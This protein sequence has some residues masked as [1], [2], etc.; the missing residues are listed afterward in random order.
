L[1]RQIVYPGAIPLD[2]DILSVQ[3]NTMLALGYLAESVFGSTT[4]VSGLAC[5]PTT[6]TADLHVNVQR[7]MISSLSTVDATA[8]GSLAADTSD[9]LVKMGINTAIW[10][11]AI[12]P[13][14]T[15]GYSQNY[16]IEAE[17]VETDTTPV[18]LPYYN[19]AAPSSP[20]S[21]PS[22][23]GVAQNT[24]RNQRVSLQLKPGTAAPAGT[25]LTPGV[26]SGWVG[27][28]VVTVNNGQTQITSADIARASGAPFIGTLLSQ[29]L[30]RLSSN[31]TLYVSPTGSDSNNGL[32][33]STA[34]ATL[35][36][37]YNSLVTQYDMAGF[38]A[39]IQCAAGTYAPL[40]AAGQPTGFSKNS[41][42]T[43]L[44]NAASPSTCVIAGASANAVAV[45]SGAQI[46][47]TGFTIQ[48][49]TLGNCLYAGL[50]SSIYHSNC[51]FG[52]CAGTHQV[53]SGGLILGLTSYSITGSAQYHMSASS[54]GTINIGGNSGTV[55]TLT[56]TPAFTAFAL[57]RGGSIL[58]NKNNVSFSGSATGSRFFATCGLIDTVGSTASSFF[59]GSTAGTQTAG[60]EYQ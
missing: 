35:N 20:Y 41:S 51:V 34:F 50:N 39:T 15:A 30:T 23:S 17:L 19:A 11:V 31:L 42:I 25:Q 28:Y 29:G 27:L 1:D 53:V 21:G 40:S 43:I 16:L 45:S 2:S 60:W 48:T 8:F 33:A 4:I 58:A 3:R 54:N 36:A 13:P 32:L 12:T 56:G 46:N 47:L 55:V 22:N 6:P 26:D 24:Q 49:T 44:G 52:A 14:G 18:V 37:A 9:P 59:P 5:L 38:S 10:T 7:G 57:T